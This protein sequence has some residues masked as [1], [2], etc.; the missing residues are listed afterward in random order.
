MPGLPALRVA[1]PAA[2]PGVAASQPRL[3]QL[4]EFLAAQLANAFSVEVVIRQSYAAIGRELL[5]GQVQLGWTPPIVA[6]RVELA[7]GFPLVRSVRNGRATYRAALICRA[8]RPV[9]I[10][11]SL[12]LRAAWVDRDS[13]A[14]YWLPRAWLRSRGVDPDQEEH[15]AGSYQAAVAAVLAGSADLAGVFTSSELPTLSIPALAELP[16]AARD[17]LRVFA[18]TDETP[19]DALCAS[20]LLA[21]EARQALERALL[22]AN[23]DALG[24]VVLHEL[25]GAE[26]FQKAPAGGYRPLYGIVLAATGL[27]A[28]AQA[29]GGCGGRLSL[30]ARFCERCG[31]PT[32]RVSAPPSAPR[33]PRPPSSGAGAWSEERKLATILFADLVGF[34]AISSR[35]EPDEVQEF[36]NSCFAPLTSEIERRGG[37]VI[38]YIGDCIMAAFG[39]PLAGEADPLR[40]VQAAKAMCARLTELGAAAQL[41]FGATVNVRIGVNT[42]LV[43]V[44]AVGGKERSGLDVMGAAVNL[45]SRIQSAASPGEVLI[46][47]ATQRLI[48]GAFELEALPP[49]N[50]K[51]IDGLVPLFRVGGER[52]DEPGAPATTAVLDAP[53][54]LREH[55]LAVLLSAFE[56]V[57]RQVQPAV[58]RLVGEAGLGKARLLRELRD[59]LG[60][61]QPQPEVLWAGAAL[62]PTPGASAPLS[63]VGRLIK[64]RFAVRV[65]EPV[66]IARARVVEGIAEVF[67]PREQTSARDSAELLADMC[68]LGL[69]EAP[70]PGGP[71]VEFRD[72]TFQAFADWL[73]QLAKERPVCL[74]V[75]NLQWA[76]DASL[77]F[78]ERLLATSEGRPL[79][80]IAGSRVELEERRPGWPRI[81]GQST[82]VQL[83]PLP[84]ARMREFVEFLLAEL[85]ELPAAIKQALVS[86]SEGNPEC[87][88]DLLRLLIDRNAIEVRNDGPWIWHPEQAGELTLPD[89]IQGVLQARLDALPREEK[90]LLKRASAIGKVFF[91]GALEAA[92]PP[93]SRSGL[94]GLLVSLERRGLLRSPQSARAGAPRQ[95]GFRT[96]A[97]RDAAYGSLPR[98]GREA[99]HR[100]VAAWLEANLPLSN[101]T[102]VAAHFEAGGELALARPHFVAAAREYAAIYAHTEAVDFYQRALRG[103]A[104]ENPG[105]NAD[106]R[107]ELA[108]VLAHMSRYDESLAALDEVTKEARAA[109]GPQLPMRLALAGSQRAFVM[110]DVGRLDEALL[111]LDEA[112]AALEDRVNL[113]CL[114]LLGQRAFIRAAK[115][116]GANAL[117][118]CDDGLR[119]AG[120]IEDHGEGWHFAAVR[121]NNSLGTLHMRAGRIDEA[122]RCFETALELCSGTRNPG[123]RWAVTVHLGNIAYDRKDYRLAASYFERALDEARRS[124]RKIKIAT[125]LSNLGQ[126]RLGAGELPGAVECLEEARALAQE[127]GMRDIQSD[128]ARALAETHLAL[129]DFA[130]GLQGATEA[131]AQAQ[132]SG[133]PTYEALAHAAAMDCLFAAGD[134]EVGR[135]KATVHFQAALTIF[136][137]SQRPEEAEALK[138][139]Y[140]R[141]GRAFRPSGSAM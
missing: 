106:T 99:A 90:E 13:T 103:P 108:T 116:D 41:R 97:L 64:S 48:G 91:E 63:L 123:A 31:E 141:A 139:R 130:T 28:S 128:S 21:P 33:A 71:S 133:S 19:S 50:L 14:G 57:V 34:T 59:R 132:L 2:A 42:G 67:P 112:L 76:D 73:H 23:E 9:D 22:T 115:G 79:L 44:G 126:A 78:L 86:R 135:A 114:V 11:S 119:I 16:P 6:A 40:A 60:Q 104:G 74:V 92:T 55:E 94:P 81:P 110:R 101:H 124:R 83:S 62:A 49:V 122:Q 26:G 140:A 1:I 136:E 93:A 32:G 131:I 20:P 35:L 45:A 18:V 77:D 37:T 137:A 68:G 4:R 36:A 43:M 5:G 89:T 134:G 30:Q 107:R 51:G 8:D 56:D 53:F 54:Q 46:G 95:L 82:T 17:Q 100:A 39:V 117:I 75:H 85:T 118:D 65:D 98:S 3:E 7:G 15:F 25:F 38:K 125:C 29:C 80:L 109:G 121:L 10:T 27:A 87:A 127:G 102:E 72:R 69:A 70:L 66:A 111:V 12:P 129:G 88:R 84:E 24:R 105:A 113:P 96:Q 138:E 120:L 61:R 52:A 58:V 47:A